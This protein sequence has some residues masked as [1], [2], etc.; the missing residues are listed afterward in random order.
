[1]T[2]LGAGGI[3]QTLLALLAPFDCDVTV[4]RR[5]SEPMPGATRTIAIGEL[6]GVLPQ[7]DVL[8]LALALTPLTRHIIGARELALLP[9]NAVL[10]NVARGGHVD[11]EALV[12]AL[13]DGEIATAALDVTEPEPLPPGHPLWAFDNVLITSH[14]ADSMAF[15]TEKLVE[16]VGENV[17]RFIAGKP[18]VGLVHPEHGY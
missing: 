16:R 4:L 7:T 5:T 1:M 9:S 18:L 12:A 15:V 13:T 14:C 6:A 3:A 17:A 8:V 2:I 10:V 11:T